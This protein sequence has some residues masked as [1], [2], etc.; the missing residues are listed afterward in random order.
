MKR[1]NTFKLNSYIEIVGL[2]AFYKHKKKEYPG[3]K[4]TGPRCT[5]HPALK[6][7]L[8]VSPVSGIM[9]GVLLLQ[10]VH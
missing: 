3:L 6:P 10:M 5:A 9:H 1:P 2:V 4:I 7:Y 8:I